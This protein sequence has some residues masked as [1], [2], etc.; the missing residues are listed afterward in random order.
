MRDAT[1]LIV[2]AAEVPADDGWLGPHERVALDVFGFERRRADWRAGRWAAKQAV[3][4]SGVV[5]AEATLA[6]LEILSADDGCP[7][8]WLG[9]ERAG[10]KLSISHRAGAAVALVCGGH[11]IAGCDLEVVERRAQ[12][13]AMDWFTPGELEAVNRATQASRD[14]LVT[15]IWS[16][17]ESALKAVRIGLRAD[18]RDVEISPGA[19][20]FVASIHGLELPGWW[21]VDGNWLMTAVVADATANVEERMRC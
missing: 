1:W 11:K 4:R 17:K 20:E 3:L 5:P 19:S 9:G 10:V 7:E 13:F 15:L 21:R 8:L 6:S 2:S 16:A 12:S 18:T 14:R